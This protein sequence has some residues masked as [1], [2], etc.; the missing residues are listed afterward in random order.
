MHPVTCSSVSLFKVPTEYIQ[1]E[2]VEPE[3]EQ[4]NCFLKQEEEKKEGAVAYHVYRAYWLAVGSCL[5][6]SVLLS[7]LLMQGKQ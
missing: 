1:E 2:D 6:L 3:E 5:A 4:P 7:L